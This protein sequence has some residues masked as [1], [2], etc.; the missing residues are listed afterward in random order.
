MPHL[1]GKRPSIFTTKVF[2]FMQ[3]MLGKR[4]YIHSVDPMR[5]V[6]IGQSY[7]ELVLRYCQ[8]N[9]NLAQEQRT[10]ISKAIEAFDKAIEMNP[11]LVEA[12]YWKGNL[13]LA[14]KLDFQEEKIECRK[15]AKESFETAF[16]KSD[17]KMTEALFK[18]VFC[19]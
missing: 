2:R 5:L 14:R 18:M 9:I 19:E 17:G 4:T 12:Y 15:I 10:Y 3:V 7:S 13:H 1:T 8:A 11:D 16:K 6:D